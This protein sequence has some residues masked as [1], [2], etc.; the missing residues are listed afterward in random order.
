MIIINIRYTLL[1]SAKVGQTHLQTAACTAER[2]EE[3]KTV[4]HKAQGTQTITIGL[5]FMQE[6]AYPH[7]LLMRR[8][9]AVDQILIAHST[10]TRTV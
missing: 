9:A 8:V 1:C 10:V 7:F 6:W 5:F 3:N 2:E 4:R